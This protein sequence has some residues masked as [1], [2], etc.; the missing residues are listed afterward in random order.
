MAEEG[1][2]SLLARAESG[3]PRVSENAY[4]ELL[5]IVRLLVRSGMG[6]K[7]RNHRD[8]GDVC[9]SIARSFVQD[10]RAQSIKFNSEGE[11]VG[12]LKTVVRSKLATLA[13][14]DG[15]T[16]R[17]GGAT[18]LPYHD[19]SIGS[20]FT[21]PGEAS[22]TI[23]TTDAMQVVQNCLSEDDLEIARLRLGGLDWE[24]IAERMGQDSQAL[25]KRW[26]RLVARLASECV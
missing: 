26:S 24:Q 22:A 7:L 15:A 23:R 18:A 16:K 8:S 6:V 3:D 21:S 1:L 19:D 5:R 17:G 4:A 12:Y 9:Q 14:S 10:H 11:L 2:H 20:E 25:R 13:R